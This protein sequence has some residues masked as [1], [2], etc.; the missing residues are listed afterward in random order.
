M[1]YESKVLISDYFF[2]LLLYLHTSIMNN[3]G[4]YIAFSIKL[5]PYINPRKYLISNLFSRI[6]QLAKK[7]TLYCPTNKK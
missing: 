6:S 4:E 7:K 1:T 5:K 3:T 2:V